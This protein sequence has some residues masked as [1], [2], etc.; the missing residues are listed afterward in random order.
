VSPQPFHSNQKYRYQIT[1]L[2][3]S[4]MTGA[5]W[6]G[7]SDEAK[8]LVDRMLN[9]DPQQRISIEEILRHPW[10]SGVAPDTDFGAD[11]VDR[12]KNLG[13]RQKIKKIFCANRIEDEHKFLRESFQEVLPFL[14]PP[15]Q[16]EVSIVDDHI[17]T[18]DFSARI[19]QLKE[20]LVSAIYQ[21]SH[22]DD[23]FDE[24]GRQMGHSKRRRL[25]HHGEIDF[26]IFCSLVSQAGLEVLAVPEV[27]QVFDTDG[28]GTI[29][30]KEFLSK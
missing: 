13:L 27:F 30:M 5:A 28:N 1:K 8:D 25:E 23:D 26:G 7:I 2:T 29:D 21:Q 12:I 15:D 14:R 19:M 18:N 10:L 3:Y 6:A 20:I 9:K 11:Y 22:P 4:P 24:E 17:S 16:S